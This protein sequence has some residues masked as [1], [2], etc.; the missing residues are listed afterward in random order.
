MSLWA[1]AI[2]VC[3]KP[4][5]VNFKSVVSESLK[6]NFG[7]L[8]ETCISSKY[9]KEKGVVVD[10]RTTH[11][12]EVFNQIIEQMINDLKKEDVGYFYVEVESNYFV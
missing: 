7:K 8:D 5:N 3:S 1:R 11:V 10:I 4:K 2:I 12:G 6:N 9:S